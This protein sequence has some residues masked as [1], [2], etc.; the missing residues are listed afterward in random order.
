MCSMQRLESDGMYG[1][2]FG[3]MY[4]IIENR[5]W[6]LFKHKTHLRFLYHEILSPGWMGLASGCVSKLYI[7]YIY[8][9]SSLPPPRQPLSH[10]RPNRLSNEYIFGTMLMAGKF[11]DLNKVIGLRRGKWMNGF[12][13][14]FKIDVTF[15]ILPFDV[16]PSPHSD[17]SGMISIELTG[18]MGLVYSF[19]MCRNSV[20]AT[21]P[22]MTECC[23]NGLE[24][25]RWPAHSTARTRN[26]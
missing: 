16:N 5:E 6:K 7:R 15:D 14:S 9:S 25:D 22:A 2:G 23:R 12:G 24:C 11:K 8:E 18:W 26:R 20:A 17:S 3:I 13:I 10:C 4:R 19:R 1:I 21:W